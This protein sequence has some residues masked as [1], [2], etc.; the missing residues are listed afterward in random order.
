MLKQYD[1]VVI[2]T[3]FASSF[4]LKKYLEKSSADKKVLILERGQFF[5]HAARLDQVR[6]KN[7]ELVGKLEEARKS[8]V[9]KNT[10]KDWPFDVNFGG[11]SNC[12]WGCV[13]RFMPSDFKL[14]SQF[15]VGADWPITYDELENYYCEA[16]AIMSIAGP[17]N[18]PYSMSRPYPQPPHQLNTIDKLMQ[19]KYGNQYISQPAARASRNVGKRSVCCTSYVCN[20]CPIDSKFTI[21]NTLKELYDDPRVTL[22]YGAKVYSFETVNN[23]IKKVLFSLDGKDEVVEGEVVA[24][25]ANSIF[26]SHILLNAGDSNKFTGSGISEQLGTYAYFYFK[27]LNNVGGGTSLSANGYMM[28]DGERRKTMS[29]CLIENHNEPFIRNEF[30]KWRHMAKFK[31][32]FE[33]IPSEENRILLTSDRFIP[34]IDYK[35]HTSYVDKAMDNLEKDIDTYFSFLPIERVELDGYFQRTEAHN[36]STTRMSENAGNGVVDKNLI[37]HQFRNLFV[38]G[39]SVFPSISAANPSLTISALSLKAADQN[40]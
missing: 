14:K 27:D 38:L 23:A 3:G 1:L 21:E 32:V 18:T 10:N 34:E 26:N 2:G 6:G 7:V 37:H 22:Q 11:S 30:G 9:N 29:S 39:G 13:P 8:F 17:D 40:F 31:F 33:D 19:E 35:K 24:L 36:L 4:F 28:Y 5:P 15:G 25:G 16:E 12:W 20:L